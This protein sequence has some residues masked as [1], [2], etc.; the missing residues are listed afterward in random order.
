MRARSNDRNRYS[1]NWRSRKRIGRMAFSML[2][3]NIFSP[4][5]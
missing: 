4:A 1:M 3:K 5:R 2:S